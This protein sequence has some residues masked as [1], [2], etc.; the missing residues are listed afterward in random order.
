MITKSKVEAALELLKQPS[1]Y[2]GIVGLLGLA[3]VTIQPPYW[4]SIVAG[5]SAL[6][7]LIAIFWQES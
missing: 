5:L 6:Y 2:K 7:F 1:T 4:E 3:G